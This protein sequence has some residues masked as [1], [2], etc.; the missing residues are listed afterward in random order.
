MTVLPDIR[1]TTSLGRPRYEGANIRT[2]IGFKHFGYLLEEAVLDHF[3]G[4]GLGPGTLFHQHGVGVE[5]VESSIQLPATLDIDDVVTTSLTPIA[6]SGPGLRFTV[7]MTVDRAGG[8]VT[9]LTGRVRV[10]FTPTAEGVREELP[11]DLREHLVS[12]VDELAS[13]VEV[14]AKEPNAFVW[15]WR[16]PY[17][18]CHLSDRLQHS[19]YA[20]AVEEVVDRFLHSRGIS[21]RTMLDGKGWIPVVS[22]SRIK[23]LG[24][25]YMEETMHTVFTVREIVKDVLYTATVDFHVQ[26]GDRLVPTAT[27]S[28]LHGYAVSRGENAGA[29]A[30]FDDATRAALLGG[31]R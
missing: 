17:F 20:R 23:V 27:A 19:G 14:P 5:F 4:R 25:A 16:I 28:I 11:E 26:R 1:Q 9:V 13:G 31:D 29:L 21:I 3:R 2:W 30:E 24:T 7:R 22:R 12:T 10:V 18:Y 8:E 15:S 6:G